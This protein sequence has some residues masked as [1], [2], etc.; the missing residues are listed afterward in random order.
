MG[1]EITHS[2]F[3]KSDFERYRK[4]LDTELDWVKKLFF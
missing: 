4:K 3:K 2:H 1:Q